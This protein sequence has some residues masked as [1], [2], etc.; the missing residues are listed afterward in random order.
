MQA[1]GTVGQVGVAAIGAHGHGHRRARRVVAVAEQYRCHH[2]HTGLSVGIAAA[3]VPGAEGDGVGHGGGGAHACAGLEEQPG[4]GRVAQHGGAGDRHGAQHAPGGAAIGCHIQLAVGGVRGADDGDAWGVHVQVADVARR[5]GQRH[6]LRQAHGACGHAASQRRAGA[7]DD[8]A[9]GGRLARVQ[10]RRG[11]VDADHV[12]P[13]GGDRTVHSG[14]GAAAVGD[15]PADGAAG[16]GGGGRVAHVAEGDAAQRRLV[17]RHGGGA[18]EGEHAGGG[19]VAAGDAVLRHKAQRVARAQARRDGHARAAEGGVVGVGQGEVGVDDRACTVF[20]EGGA[21]HTDGDHRGG[22]A[23]CPGESGGVLASV[24]LHGVGV[25]ASGWVG[26][27][28][29]QAG[30]G[31]GF[32]QGKHEL[33]AHHGH[34]ADGQGLPARRDGECRRLRLAGGRD[35]FVK[36]Q[37]EL[38]R[39]GRVARR[40]GAWRCGVHRLAEAAFYVAAAGSVGERALGHGDTGIALGAC[41]RGEGGRVAAARAAEVRQAAA[42]HAD[43]G[44]GEIGRG[45]AEREGQRRRLA[46]VQHRAAAADGHR[47]AIAGEAGGVGFPAGEHQRAR[48]FKIRIVRHTIAIPI[49]LNQ[50][51]HATKDRRVAGAGVQV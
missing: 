3:A 36:A 23:Q 48:D 31:G 1:P 39:V 22:V 45:D 6:D 49:V 44:G 33:L 43:I 32:G 10:H 41:C 18:A 25:V 13:T 34:A 8:G 21:G 46:S 38:A 19:V 26:V 42:G 50:P 29:R 14:Q 2:V 37:R 51:R 5:A 16:A 28:H 11:V 15:L 35:R 27:D 17:L 24:V 7:Q 12:H 47:R 40:G 20:G 4:V 30:T 9:Q